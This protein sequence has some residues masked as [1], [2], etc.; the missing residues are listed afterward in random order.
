M[1]THSQ[2]IDPATDNTQ[3]SEKRVAPDG[4][5]L[6]S[7]DTDTTS[8]FSRRQRSAGESASHAALPPDLP[9]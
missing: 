4:N 6:S 7:A 2:H 9:G 1:P 8:V 3:T 5:G